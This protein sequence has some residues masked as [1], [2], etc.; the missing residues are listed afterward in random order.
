MLEPRSIDTAWAGSA[1]GDLK[2]Q[3]RD[4][5]QPY[6]LEREDRKSTQEHRDALDK[7]KT[8]VFQM[9]LKLRHLTKLSR[10]AVAREGRGVVPEAVHI[11]RCKWNRH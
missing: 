7:S 4:R 8:D 11:G 3:E 10:H 5:L 2:E 9:D 1:K 6:H